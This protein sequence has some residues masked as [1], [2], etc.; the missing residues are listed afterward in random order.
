MPTSANHH[1]PEGRIMSETLT[2]G[3]R[4]TAACMLALLLLHLPLVGCGNNA[5]GTVQSTPE[6]RR[7]LIPHVS[8]HPKN[9]KLMSVAGKP[10]S[11]KERAERPAPR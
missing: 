3:P 10:L 8:E 1:N 4:V 6:A 5:E 9:R 11:I 2:E 7:R